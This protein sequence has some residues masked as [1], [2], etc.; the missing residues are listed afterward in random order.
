MTSFKRVACLCVARRCRTMALS[1]AML[2][3]GVAQVRADF[4][5]TDKNNANGVTILTGNTATKT[6]IMETKDNALAP[7]VPGNVPGFR[8]TDTDSSPATLLTSP[9]AGADLRQGVVQ[10]LS[11]NAENGYV[12]TVLGKP[13]GNAITLSLGNNY[14]TNGPGPDLYITAKNVDGS[15]VVQTTSTQDKSFSV[16]FHMLN[17]PAPG[18]HLYNPTALPSNF[19]P[20]EGAGNVLGQIDLSNLK[21]ASTPGIYNDGVDLNSI[22][23]FIPSGVLIDFITLVNDNAANAN[24]WGFLGNNSEAPTGFVAR[25]DF[26]NADSDNNPFTGVDYLTGRYGTRYTNGQDGPQAW[27]VG[28]ENITPTPEPASIALAGLGAIGLS[29]YALKRRRKRRRQACS[30]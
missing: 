6:Y 25:R 19:Q 26:D 22:A 20:P 23:T 2:L 24:A 28:L 29:A 11:G 5:L 3:A 8:F 1:A 14:L 13:W 4:I 18:W 17:G 16:A 21:L 15:G 9:N 7:S 12:G 27:F 30:A 10:N